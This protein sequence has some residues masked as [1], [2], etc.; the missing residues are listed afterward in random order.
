MEGR[1]KTSYL[2]L[3]FLVYISWLII[4]HFMPFLNRLYDFRSVNKWIIPAVR[5]ALMFL[6]TYLFVRIYE[7]KTFASGFNFTFQRFGKNIL[8]AFVFFVSAGVVLMGYQFLIVKPLTKKVIHASGV[9]SRGDIKPFYER[10]IEYL[11]IVYEGIIE[12]FIF[13]GFLLDRLAKKWKWPAALIL[14]N[15][16]FA[17]W[18]YSYWSKG[19]LE[20]SLMIILTFLAGSIISLSYIKTE[21]ALSPVICHTLVDSPASVRILLGL[22]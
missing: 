18:H 1:P 2:V 11:Y 19:W 12:V 7:K 17:L 15:I 20:G 9:I 3:V 14:G 21:N 13:I 10:L 5:M 16:L 22:M 4:D 8:W 6:I